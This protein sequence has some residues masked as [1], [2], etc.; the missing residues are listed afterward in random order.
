MK[1]KSHISMLNGSGSGIDPCRTPYSISNSRWNEELAL[2][3]LIYQ[4]RGYRYVLMILDP[5]H[6]Y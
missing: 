3:F 1:R 2:T 5:N 6:S 4:K